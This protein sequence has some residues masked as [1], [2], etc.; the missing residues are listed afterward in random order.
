MFLEEILVEGIDLVEIVLFFLCVSC[1][2][3]VKL[4]VLREVMYYSVEYGYVDVIIDIRSIGVL[5]ILYMWLEFLW[6]VF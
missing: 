1:N 4:R 6:I 3:K 5:W 2:S